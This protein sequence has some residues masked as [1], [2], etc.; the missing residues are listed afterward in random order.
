MHLREEARVLT[1]GKRFR[2]RHL[3]LTNLF[4]Q[5]EDYLKWKVETCSRQ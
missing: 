4:V 5:K 3:S 1:R 2:V